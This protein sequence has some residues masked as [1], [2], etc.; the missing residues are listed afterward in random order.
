MKR[1]AIENTASEPELMGTRSGRTHSERAVLCII[2][3]EWDR[4]QVATTG[5]KT[6]YNVE[7]KRKEQESSKERIERW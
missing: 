4:R 3:I 5:E 1:E 2:V 7:R 6:E